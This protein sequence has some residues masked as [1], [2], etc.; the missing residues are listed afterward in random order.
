[1]GTCF[2]LPLLDKVEVLLSVIVEVVGVEVE[3]EVLVEKVCTTSD[4]KV[5]NLFDE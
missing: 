4:E 1:M 3:V 5:C 2:I